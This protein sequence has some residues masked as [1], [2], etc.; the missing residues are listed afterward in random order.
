[1]SQNDRVIKREVSY[2]S[3]KDQAI[4]IRARKAFMINGVKKKNGHS[5][6]NICSYPYTLHKISLKWMIMALNNI[7]SI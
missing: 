4:W 2:S 7:P 5:Y 3:T 6:V 1:M